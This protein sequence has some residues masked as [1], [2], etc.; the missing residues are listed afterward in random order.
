M[1]AGDRL[2]FKLSSLLERELHG[3]NAECQKEVGS[4]N[5]RD[6][7]EADAFLCCFFWLESKQAEGT[8]VAVPFS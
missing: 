1:P 6:E 3:C 2:S 5:S 8:W 7:A 4:G